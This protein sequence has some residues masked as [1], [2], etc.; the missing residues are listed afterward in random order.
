MRSVAAAGQRLW[1]VLR[2]LPNDLF[3]YDEWNVASLERRVTSLADLV[4]LSDAHWL[5]RGPSLGYIA[6]PFL[7][8]GERRGAVL[9]E[10][11]SHKRPRRGW[12]GRVPLDGSAHPVRVI[13]EPH[14]LSYPCVV[15]DGETVYCVPESA[16][17][18]TTWLYRLDPDGTFRRGPAI[19]RDAVVLDPTVFIHDQ[20]WW[21]LGSD[22]RNRGRYALVAYW[23]DSPE[24]PWRPHPANPLKCDYNGGRPAGLVF[25]L[26]DRLYRPGQ[27][28]RATYGAAVVIHEILELSPDA[29]REEPVLRI[30]P[31][32]HGPYP[33]GLHHIVVSDDLVVFDGKRSH[34]DPLF[35]L[36]RMRHA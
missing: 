5:P 22:E 15:R 10:V 33:H 1:R 19:V 9:V 12:I 6:D 11:Y 30:E 24:G 8:P 17:T 7:L 31:D 21:L 35:W 25:R 23:A 32:P 36:K 18:R 3:Q 28:C 16:E 13:V 2:D 4:D 14:H 27:D 34:Y 26:G 29:F 20:R